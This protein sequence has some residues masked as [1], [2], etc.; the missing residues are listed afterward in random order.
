MKLAR[1]MRSGG[2][3]IPIESALVWHRPF[4]AHLPGRPACDSFSM[5][6]RA[7]APW[8]VVPVRA[9][10]P[11]PELV[12]NAPT[13]RTFACLPSCFTLLQ[14]TSWRRRG[15]TA[16]LVLGVPTARGRRI[17]PWCDSPSQTIEKPC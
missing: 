15:P 16:H 13:V 14:N 7:M 3:G 10:K 5:R 4:S 11:A 12:G 9:P 6:T 1:E 8:N 2:D 17:A